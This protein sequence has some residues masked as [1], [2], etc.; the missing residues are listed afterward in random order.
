MKKLTALL[1]ILC[2]A[3]GLCACTDA[4]HDSR[5]SVHTDISLI[6]Y[7]MEENLGL[8]PDALDR[9]KLYELCYDG[10]YLLLAQYREKSG[11][12]FSYML[13]VAPDPDEFFTG[14]AYK[15]S[16]TL[17]YS[18]V[19]PTAEIIEQN[20]KSYVTR[21]SFVLPDVPFTTLDLVSTQNGLIQRVIVDGW[22]E[23]EGF[24]IAYRFRY[25]GSGKVEHVGV[26]S[27]TE[28]ALRDLEAIMLN[29][30]FDLE[31]RYIY[32]DDG[33]LK[34]FITPD[35]DKLLYEYE[36]GERIKAELYKDQKTLTKTITYERDQDGLLTRARVSDNDAKDNVIY[37]FTYDG[38]KVYV[39]PTVQK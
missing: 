10:R 24:P 4:G 33:S 25:D 15:G 29:P 37:D 18:P 14:K 17:L 31:Y 32:N 11:D 19:S 6:R 3:L 20:K 13:T 27:D 9:F 8:D 22:G 36:D 21:L 39:T 7:E 26:F 34:A 30:R 38:G 2:V 35:G 5:C 12:D 23:Y 28:E 16:K 1:L